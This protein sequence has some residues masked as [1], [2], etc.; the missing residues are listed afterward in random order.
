MP[1]NRESLRAN[2]ELQA[3]RLQ[4]VAQIQDQVLDA[5]IKVVDLPSKP[6]IDPLESLD[7][8]LKTVRQ[9]LSLFRPNDFDDMVRERN[10][11]EKCGY[12]LCSKSV[13][14]VNAD[15]AHRILWAKKGGRDLEVT[16]SNTEKWCSR[17]CERLALFIKKQLS[18]EAAWERRAAKKLIDVPQLSKASNKSVYD[19]VKGNDSHVVAQRLEELSL[20]R[21]DKSPL[22]GENM[23]IFENPGG[24]TKIEPPQITSSNGIEGYHPRDRAG[25]EESHD[26][27]DILDI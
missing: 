23:Q 25:S 18:D 22:K 11:Y 3:R 17:R 7:D 20:E 2:A 24:G 21:G 15:P 13:E 5:V 26:D 12:C 1:E 4:E 19:I 27:Q 16:S 10:I 9:N 14:T 6:N 8:D